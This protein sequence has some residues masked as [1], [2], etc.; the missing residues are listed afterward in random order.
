MSTNI[1]V[2]VGDSNLLDKAR[3]QQ[4]ASRQRQLKKESNQRLSKEA[5]IERVNA[6]AAQ[7]KDA[8]GNSLTG[9]SSR[10]NTGGLGSRG[11]ASLY[12]P[13][14]S[15]QEQTFVNG[16]GVKVTYS[17]PVGTSIDWT[18]KV[19]LGSVRGTETVEFVYPY[20]TSPWYAPLP[21]SSY[22]DDWEDVPIGIGSP[23]TIADPPGSID[24]NSEVF[25]GPTERAQ[26]LAQTGS[27][28]PSNSYIVERDLLPIYS[29]SDESRIFTL[30]DGRGGTYVIFVLNRL[31][32]T[33]KDRVRKTLVGS[34]TVVAETYQTGIFTP[35]NDYEYIEWV[36]TPVPGDGDGYVWKLKDPNIPFEKDEWWTGPNTLTV[37]RNTLVELEESDYS[38]HLYSVKGNSVTEKLVPPVLE[39]W[40]NEICPPLTWNAQTTIP[41][42]TGAFTADSL[43]SGNNWKQSGVF[44]A[45]NLYDEEWNAFGFPAIQAEDGAQIEYTETRYDY[46]YD[47]F[48]KVAYIANT[49]AYDPDY[50]SLI[51]ALGGISINTPRAYGPSFAL[52]YGKN[53]KGL[54]TAQSYSYAYMEEIF[55]GKAPKQYISKCVFPGSCPDDLQYSQYDV[56]WYQ[57]KQRPPSYAE[58]SP[59]S[60]YRAIPNGAFITPSHLR[61]GFTIYWITN[62]GDNSLC[63]QALSPLGL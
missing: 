36:G 6:L 33:Q 47:S 32:K 5:E 57:S 48:N 11:G 39:A 14:A 53:I 61:E 62:W 15:R 54:T 40:M 60:S 12:E 17:T 38:I 45:N 30:P 18:V 13:A 29:G 42:G 24:P 2:I 10:G 25:V 52:S 34:F 37:T 63:I 4:S 59:Q 7:G 55:F 56:T 20:G 43:L 35:T 27:T 41:G 46:T 1:N 22:P 49:T 8:N 28:D 44:V 19:A 9:S 51:F 50:A 58:L 23:G 21:P 26:L 16:V 3:L 31:L